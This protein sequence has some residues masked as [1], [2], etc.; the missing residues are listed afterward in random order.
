MLAAGEDREQVA[1][2]VRV[3]ADGA[4][5]VDDQQ[6]HLRELGQDVLMAMPSARAMTSLRARS[7]IRV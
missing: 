1:G 4:E 3:D 7:S 6:V 5:I 2:R